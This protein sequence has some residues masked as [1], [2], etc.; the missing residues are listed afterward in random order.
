MLSPLYGANE[1]SWAKPL[2]EWGRRRG[3]CSFQERERRRGFDTFCRG[4]GCAG[5]AF[6]GDEG[7]AW[8]WPLFEMARMHGISP[9]QEMGGR[10]GLGPYWSYWGV[11]GLTL[12]EWERMPALNPLLKQETRCGHS[13]SIGS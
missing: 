4:R 3:L 5:L 9:F 13:G 6:P 2:F 11:A 7:K 1:G 8:A 10:R 12:I